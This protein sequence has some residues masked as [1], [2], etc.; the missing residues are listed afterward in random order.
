MDEPVPSCVQFGSRWPA[1]SEH[2]TVDVDELP[3]SAR[4]DVPLLL[5]L[6]SLDV[7]PDDVDPDEVDP[8]FWLP[9]LFRSI[10]E[11]PLDAATI[12]AAASVSV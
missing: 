9:P 6:E 10:H 3:A 11:Q 1:L 12:R 7:D 4:R 2:G 5:L 8:V